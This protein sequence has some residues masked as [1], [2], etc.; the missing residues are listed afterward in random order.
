M[1]SR[2]R[3][4]KTLGK[5]G[6]NTQKTIDILKDTFKDKMLNKTSLPPILF[7]TPFYITFQHP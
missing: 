5:T 1:F 2:E 6:K 4:K 7:T 3:K